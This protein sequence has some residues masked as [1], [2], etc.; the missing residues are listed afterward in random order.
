MGNLSNYIYN[1][2]QIAGPVIGI[3]IGFTTIFGFQAYYPISSHN[4][5]RP[6]TL[7]LEQQPLSSSSFDQLTRISNTFEKRQG[8]L[9]YA[10]SPCSEK[11]QIETP[12]AKKKPLRTLIGNQKEDCDKKRI[13]A[14]ANSAPSLELLLKPPSILSH[15]SS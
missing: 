1:N 11:P 7:I 5:H 12:K 10:T 15:L 8:N 14:I 3:M 2:P 4:V 13:T 9:F 6:E